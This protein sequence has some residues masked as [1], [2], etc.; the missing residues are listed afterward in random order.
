[1]LSVIIG[2]VQGM[3]FPIKVKPDAWAADIA[4]MYTR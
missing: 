2:L 3:G 4:D 1:M